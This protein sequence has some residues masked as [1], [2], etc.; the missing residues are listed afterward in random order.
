M[1]PPSTRRR[2]RRAG[3]CSRGCGRASSPPSRAR[4]LLDGGAIGAVVSV[5][6]DFGVAGDP[7]IGEYPTD[8]IFQRELGG[9]AVTLLGPY[10]V[11]AALL[12]L[13]DKPTSVAASG[14]VDASV[15]DGGG[16][17]ELS[18][19]ATLTFADAR[20]PTR[21]GGGAIATLSCSLLAESAEEVTF[22]GTEGTLTLRP[23]AHCPTELVL[24]GKG[25][26]RGGGGSEPEVYVD[27]LPA[28]RR[29]SSPPAA[30]SCPTRSASRTRPPSPRR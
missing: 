5:R 22:V 8:T 15:A 17:A 12:A 23:P 2:R 14:L 4:A 20:K 27:A 10:L 18:A 24:S 9:G 16:G 29:R 25:G 11:Q 21:L 3:W 7:D 19:S 13:G 6:G 30:S 1:P 28:S 26:G